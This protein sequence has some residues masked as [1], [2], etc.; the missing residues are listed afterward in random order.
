MYVEGYIVKLNVDVYISQTPPYCQFTKKLNNWSM[1]KAYLIICG[2]LLVVS[3]S[4]WSFTGGFW[5]FVVVYG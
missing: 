1:E 4:F 2:C 5:W 3:G